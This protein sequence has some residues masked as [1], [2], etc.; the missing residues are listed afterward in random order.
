M[1]YLEV[2]CAP[3]VLSV[4]FC[5]RQRRAVQTRTAATRSCDSAVVLPDASA[6][7]LGRLELGMRGFTVAAANLVI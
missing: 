6:H 7:P 4:M 2:V 5:T 1:T 3:L